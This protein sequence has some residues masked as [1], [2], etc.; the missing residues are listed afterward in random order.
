MPVKNYKTITIFHCV[1][2]SF[3]SY[4]ISHESIPLIVYL[5]P[6]PFLFSISSS[7]E[8]EGCT[9]DSLRWGRKD[10]NVIYSRRWKTSKHF[11]TYS[12]NTR[13]IFKEIKEIKQKKV[14]IDWNNYMPV[15][16]INL[17]FSKL[18]WQGWALIQLLIVR[19]TTPISFVL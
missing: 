2:L 11:S 4:S 9:Q 3:V 8:L 12:L 13:R 7:T 10:R 17:G 19:I 14:D 16:D 15:I 1:P 5:D 18:K 6:F